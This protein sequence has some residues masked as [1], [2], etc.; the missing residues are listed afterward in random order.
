[1][2]RGRGGVLVDPIDSTPPTSI[3]ASEPVDIQIPVVVDQIPV[4]LPMHAAVEPPPYSRRYTHSIDCATHAD[5][6]NAVASVHHA[7]Y[8]R[9][10]RLS[11]R[12]LPPDH[13]AA[14]LVAAS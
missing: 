4:S 7:S 14:E 10:L 8:P 5:A 3:T 11:L 2:S 12:A 9:A 13:V 1:M 6:G